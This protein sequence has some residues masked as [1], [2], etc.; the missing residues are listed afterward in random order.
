MK[1]IT[2]LFFFLS[3][4]I[5]HAQ[6]GVN[7]T[8]PDPSSMLDITATNKGVLVPRVSLANVTTTM[9]DGTNTAATGLL[10][11]N[12]NATTVGGNGVG[13]YF[14]NGTQWIPITQTI[15]GNTLDQSY[16]QGGAG[17]GRTITADN[18]AVL[19][20]GN[21]GF[22]NTG[23]FGSGSVLGLT[24]SGTR[25]FFYPRKAAFRAGFA[26]GTNWNDVNIGNYSVA[27][28]NS[29][30]ATND[31]DVA[32]GIG[33]NATG[34]YSTALGWANT[35]SGAY[36]FSLGQNAT[37]S[38]WSSTAL[39]RVSSALGSQSM[40]FGHNSTIS[41][42][43]SIGL[44]NDVQ[45]SG[46]N[47]IGIGNSVEVPSGFEMALG[48][49]NTLY[50]PL[51]IS[52]INPNDRLFSIGNGTST[53]ARSNALTIYKDGRMNIN[54]AYTM[55]SSD[56][57]NGQVMQTDGAGIVSWTTPST[58]TDDQNLVT[59]TLTGTTL[60]L[61]IENGTGTSI[62]LAPLQDGTGTDD[63]TIDN[64]SLSG[65]TL[66]L[67]LENDGQP[68][69][70][71]NLA[72]INTDDQNLVTP[73][74][75]GTTLN[76]NIENGTGTSIDLAPLNDHDWYEIGGTNPAD[77][78]TDAI[79]TEGRVTV[80]NNTLGNG[81]LNI[82]GTNATNLDIDNSNSG[83]QIG[84]NLNMSSNFSNKI[85]INTSFSGLDSAFGGNSAF[86]ENNDSAIHGGILNGIKQT[87]SGQNFGS[88]VYGLYNFFSPLS[89]YQSDMYGIYNAI[90]N[91]SSSGNHYGT[92]NQLIGT[93]SGNKYGSWNTID[94]SA[95]GTHYGVYSNVLKAGSYAGYFLGNVS[96]GTTNLNNYILPTSRGTNGQ[97]MQTNGTGIVSWINPSTIFTDTD[98]QSIDELSL[99]G[100]TLNISLAN[101]G[102]PT[103]T[104]NLTSLKNT[105]DQAYDQGGLGAGRTIFATDGAVTIAGEDGLQI[106]GTFGTGDAITLAGAGTRLFFNPRKASFRAGRALGTEWNNVNVG[107]YSTGFGIGNTASG[108]ASAVFGS[109]N[110]V[111]ANNSVAFG[112][113]NSAA[114]FSSIVFGELNTADGAFSIA[115]GTSAIASGE[116]SFALGQNVSALG[117]LSIAFGSA[118]T[119][120]V[121]NGVV[122]GNNI[123]SFSP[124]ETVIGTNSTNYTPMS[125]NSF[126]TN[127]R[128]FTI[129]NGIN[130]TN[131]SNALTIYKDGRMNIN[132]A[133][134]LPTVDGAANQFL[135]T[136]GLGTVSWANATSSNTFTNGLTETSGN[137]VLGGSLTENT[138]ILNNNFN[139]TYNLNGTGDFTIQDNG[140][141][142][143][144]VSDIGNVGIGVASTGSKLDV[145]G[146]GFVGNFLNTS[147]GNTRILNV[148]HS[149]TDP[150]GFGYVNFFRS[151]NTATGAIN[152][153]A[154]GNGIVYTTVSDR[155]L[156][157]NIENIIAPLL[158]ISKIQPKIYEYKS[159]P[160][161][162]EYGFIAQ[163]LK[164]VYPQAVSGSPDSDVETNPMMV[165]YS[166]LTPLLT[167]GVKELN[168]E[169]EQFKKQ[170]ALLENRLTILEKENAALKSI[171]EKVNALEA[172]LDQMN[173]K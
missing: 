140:T 36:S 158:L 6:V 69:Q 119:A 21:D 132:D 155:R 147:T 165:D 115:A 3:N 85:G 20:Q 48:N 168:E 100:D 131:R 61:N 116:T 129:G 94:T 67:S 74:L 64:F 91:N 15:T 96:I 71:V 88:N 118:S 145:Q 45:I 124:Y 23:T 52:T 59:P 43:N 134:T 126:N 137:V 32:I 159:K 2:V 41:G 79:Y 164:E 111:S 1:K 122:I 120:N 55:P 117:D 47:S 162:K 97:I 149:S 167:A 76:L 72:S 106:T 14:F 34:S 144:Q 128:L 77:D 50:T 42:D 152:G 24:G 16:D 7:T 73:T 78:I 89:G 173:I 75:V 54:D 11:W 157:N 170:N 114:G 154:T 95:G 26:F 156:K 12:T 146:P 148:R 18:G 68:L 90:S 44:G 27:M 33:S 107:D 163:E 66:R 86:I 25:L 125:T 82:R 105:L 80:G 121:S 108:S 35:A 169:I 4:V 133:Y 99:S 49:Y 51:S 112:N 160:G 93:G 103:Q 92:Y 81:Q 53:V 138:T 102:V 110:I 113:N 30:M 104:L 109:S 31:Y 135:Q 56:G 83:N 40:V 5:L 57:T 130:P 62:D 46:M 70:T 22:Q 171:V 17:V 58:A 39:G 37:A 98:D 143:F 153:S 84:I 19:V 87:F 63:Q 142:A 166:R 127:D 141:T 38:G 60:N 13:F 150:D 8:T 10:I 29:T 139:A 151:I 136:D 28:G 65:T 123:Q 101:D 161:I 9:L 172:K